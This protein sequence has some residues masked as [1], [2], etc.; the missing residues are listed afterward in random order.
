MDEVGINTMFDLTP[1]HQHEL[2]LLCERYR[3]RRLELF[4]SAAS[5]QFDPK[6]SDLDFLVEFDAESPVGPFHQFFDF[7]LAL[8]E[9]F[10]RSIDL[11][12][13]SAIRNEY[14]RQAVVR[15]PR[16]LLYAA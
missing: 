13:P 3:V 9:L 8:E 11:V 5:D 14:F 10:G 1:Q 16:R 15:G 2:Q 4:G 6:A 7:L 12:E